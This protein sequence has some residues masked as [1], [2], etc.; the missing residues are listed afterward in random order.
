MI[1]ERDD[2]LDA[3]ARAWAE[4]TMPPISEGV[5]LDEEWREQ[6]EAGCR[7]E[8]GAMLAIQHALLVERP[9]LANA[10]LP[11]GQLVVDRRVLVQAWGTLT[12]V[13]KGAPGTFRSRIHRTIGQID[14]ALERSSRGLN[15]GGFPG[16]R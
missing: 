4:A 10:L 13:L 7:E 16:V 15:R 6:F 5:V 14:Q 9:W 8:V 11:D 2:L 1:A 3:L 12:A